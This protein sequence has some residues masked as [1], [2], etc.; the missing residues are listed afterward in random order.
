M[1]WRAPG[2]INALLH[3]SVAG[4]MRSKGFS[5]MPTHIADTIGSKIVAVAALLPTCEHMHTQASTS[6]TLLALSGT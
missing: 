1:V 2:S 4:I 3:A 6:C 5:P